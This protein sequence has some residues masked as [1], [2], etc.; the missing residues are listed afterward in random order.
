M[1]NVSL[2]I[3][4]AFRLIKI[5]VLENLFQSNATKIVVAIIRTH[6]PPLIITVRVPGTVRSKGRATFFLFSSSSSLPFVLP[7]VVLLFFVRVK[8][9]I[10][11]YYII[12]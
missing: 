12:I 5:L 9:R 3:K 6:P 7:V 10:V 8:R 11:W 1:V 4:C 2:K